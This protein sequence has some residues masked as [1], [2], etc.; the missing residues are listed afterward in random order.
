MLAAVPLAVAVAVFGASF[1]VL[2]R[3]AGIDGLSAVLMSATT[4][5][6]SAQFAAVAVVAHG[7]GVLTAVI[8]VALLNARY[9]PIGASV[10]AALH[11]QPLRRILEAQLVVD[12][13]WALGTRDGRVRRRVL[14]GAGLTLYLAF[15][16]GTIVGVVGGGFVGDPARLGL[17]AAFPALFLALV[18]SQLGSAR[19]RSAAILG[20][21][22]ALAL[23]PFTRPGVPIVAASLACLVGLRR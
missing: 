13:S 17:D 10:A 20:I 3:G 16:G 5:A 1:G 14:L 4:F 6:G 19:A 8:A 7:G 12:E 9:V 23:V 11:R 2:A 18:W 22:I 15:L 21:V